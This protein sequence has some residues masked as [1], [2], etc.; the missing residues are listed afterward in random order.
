[1]TGM[2]QNQKYPGRNA[3][4]R[5]LQQKPNRGPHGDEANTQKS[6]KSCKITKITE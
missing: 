6:R 5:K 4:C 2:M 1:M 3:K